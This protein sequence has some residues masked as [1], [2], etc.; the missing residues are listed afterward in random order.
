MKKQVAGRPFIEEML[1]MDDSEETSF[2][3][4]QD[5]TGRRLRIRRTREFPDGT[6]S[7]SERCLSFGEI[8]E[9][10]LD[11]RDKYLS[12]VAHEQEVKLRIDD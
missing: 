5:E 7:M 8:T 2:R 1:A 4:V 6:K 9:V 10:H 11:Y 12:N 3:L